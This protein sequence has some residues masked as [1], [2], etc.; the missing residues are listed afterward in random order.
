M[1]ERQEQAPAPSLAAVF[2]DLPDDFW[3]WCL[4]E[5]I[6]RGWLTD[7]LPWLPPEGVQEKYTGRSGEP[8]LS[9][10]F[11]FFQLCK[12]ELGRLGLELA[13]DS[14]V[15][16]FGCGWGRITRLLLKDVHPR[17]VTG[18]DMLDEAI[19]ICRKSNFPCAFERISPRPPIFY[20]D[21]SLDYIFAY[22]VFTH[23]SEECARAWIGEF[24]RILK[25]GGVVFA[26]IRPPE[27]VEEF[28]RLRQVPDI[29]SSGQ[30][31]AQA[32]QDLDR[33]R[34]DYAAG[35]FVFEPS[36]GASPEGA[37]FG[38]ALIPPA[39]AQRNY[40]GHFPEIRI[41]E[42]RDHGRFDQHLLILR[43]APRPVASAAGPAAEPA[44]P[45]AREPELPW[46]GERL[47]TSLRGPIVGEHLHR[48]AL[49][50]ELVAGRTVLDVACGEGY[51]SHLLGRRARRVLG[52]DNSPETIE[53]A[54]AKYGRENVE[55]QVGSAEAIPLPD[56]S[57]DAVVTFE[58][59]EHLRAPGPFLAEIRR[60]LGPRG[61]LVI[62]SP[63]REPYQE[64]TPEPNVFHE[65][66][67]THAQFAEL[68]RGTFRHVFLARQR[69]LQGS[70]MAP[71]QED[72]A[73]RLGTFSGNFNEVSFHPGVNRGIYSIAVC[74]DA[75]LER[76][77][78]GVFESPLANADGAWTQWAQVQR[79]LQELS[80]EY[81]QLAAAHALGQRVNA[82]LGFLRAEQE[83]DRVLQETRLEQERES[84]RNLSE[85]LEQARERIGELGRELERVN[86]QKHQMLLTLQQ[87]EQRLHW[88]RHRHQKMRTQLIVANNL[89]RTFRGLLPACKRAS[90]RKWQRIRRRVLP[91]AQARRGLLHGLWTVLDWPWRAWHARPSQ[92]RLVRASG[93][94]DAAYYLEQVPD[95]AARGLDP[96]KHYLARGAEEGRNPSALFDTSFYLRSNPDVD[97][98]GV[99]P[100]VHFIQSGMDEER[101]PSPAFDTQYYLENN[102]D[103]V[104]A[105]VSAFPHYYHTGR[106]EG[107]L[108]HAHG[109][110]GDSR[111]ESGGSSP[112]PAAPAGEDGDG[113]EPVEPRWR[114]TVDWR[115]RP[116]PEPGNVKCIAFYLPQFHPVPEN[117]EW[118]GEGFTEWEMVS[119]AAPLFHG[120]YQPHRPAELGFY[121]LRVPEVREKQAAMARAFGIQGFCYYYYWFNGQRLLDR[122]LQEVL[123]SGRPDFPFCICW[124]NEN[125][126]RRWDGQDQQV[127]IE[128]G[129][130]FESDVAFIRDVIPILKDPR[131]LRFEGKPVLLVYRADK[132]RDPRATARA[133]RDL[134]AQAGI[135][136]LH[137]C[138]VEILGTGQPQQR[139]FDALVEFPPNSYLCKNIAHSV[140]GLHPQFRGQIF[141]YRELAG[142]S[143]Q[144]RPE[145]Y[146]YHR[147]VM[148]MWDNTARTGQDARIF[149]HARPDLYEHWLE[150]FVREAKSRRDQEALIFI[151]AW[152]EW[153]EGAHLEPDRRHGFG[154]LEATARALSAK[155]GAARALPEQPPAAAGPEPSGAEASHATEGGEEAA[156]AGK[157]GG[158]VLVVHNALQFG[159]QFLSLALA[160]TWLRR[161]REKMFVLL[162]QGGE[163]EPA[164]ARTGHVINLE[165]ETRRLGSEA[166]ALE[167]IR[168]RLQAA[169]VDRCLCNSVVTGD[170]ARFFKQQGCRVVSLVHELPALTATYGYEHLAEWLAASSDRLIFPVEAVRRPF[171][172]RFAVPDEKT[173]IRPQGIMRPNPYLQRREW[174]RRTLQKRHQLGPDFKLV[175]NCAYG[176]LRKGPDLFLAVARQV[177]QQRAADNVHFVWAGAFERELKAWCEHDRRG[178]AFADRVHFIGFQQDDAVYQAAADILALTSREDPLPH[179]ML[180]AMEAGVPVVAF[181]GSGGADEILADGRG[182]LVPY[183]D[184]AGMAGA[185]AG[186]LLDEER[187]RDIGRRAAET[188]ARSFRFE[189]YV[190]FIARQFEKVPAGR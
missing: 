44:L 92:R 112:A 89:A 142:Q 103:L 146:P 180:S 80:E 120:H 124:A 60:C 165:S 139:G 6:Q 8:A 7:L 32:F 65:Q 9:Q 108:A 185:I 159:T 56:R 109:A 85:A 5:G 4:T 86:S 21:E 97:E 115:R 157:N 1:E 128:Q 175:L 152:N 82:V 45:P 140:R 173:L 167:R 172:E 107:R 163:L 98:F 187:R 135:P 68:L 72:P 121:D 132:L 43:K 29:P 182:V 105:G 169:G 35:R 133:W 171:V 153:G 51:G 70:F 79:R 127:L 138:M 174:A 151:N 33:V 41:L 73:P 91:P 2:H 59:I 19:R 11:G 126:T 55:F 100:L 76:V 74:S 57:V 134:C 162:K 181:A 161:Y 83:K 137:L 67:L 190:D 177:L 149:H 90:L 99:N 94:F 130:S 189:D 64:A 155:P 166:A 106:R 10:A 148:G 48:Y 95:L 13:P 110:G 27:A 122:P 164:F 113:R 37:C 143:L 12:Q 104:A 88:Q 102:S 25:P 31:A 3:Y 141:D 147:T 136:G 34:R 49:A 58:T 179:V 154:W 23:L 144:H 158:I 93:L 84:N 125:W 30:T 178:M 38:E 39:Y 117:D 53:H 28:A 62:S 66:E 69:F 42:S 150:T 24:R 78:M 188:I 101:D 63:D 183:L 96:V 168:R 87:F 116:Q 17:N 77:P 46:T 50:A 54:R 22:S 75:P 186:L 16:D 15:L 131:Y 123:A 176:D 61:V 36:P 156:A 47:V 145:G 18:V 119:R 184:V 20:A 129:H 111:A 160:E 114:S 26:T 71:D 14:R 52:V 118:W 81:R 170:L 40:S